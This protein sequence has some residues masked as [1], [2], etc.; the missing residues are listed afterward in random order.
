MSRPDYVIVGPDPRRTDIENPGGQLTATTGLL[1]YARQEGL[2]LA[3]IDTL[4]G[5]FPVPPGYVRIAKVI[6]R[7]LQFLWYSSV[8]RPRMGAIIFSAGPGSFVERGMTGLIARLFRVRAVI[9]IRSGRLAPLLGARSPSGIFISMLAR[10]QP[11]ILVQGRS[12]LVDLERAGVE[13][14][15]VRVVPNW[16]SP[17]RKIAE[18]P[19]FAAEGKPIRFLFVGWLVVEKGIREL[20]QA[21]LSLASAGRPFHLT[22]VGGGN[23]EVELEK[24]IEKN[25]ISNFVSLAGWVKPD[26]VEG[27]MKDADVFVLPT[28]FEGLPNALV[29]A[30]SVGLPAISTPVG[31]IPDSLIDQHNGFLVPPRDAVSLAD[32]MARYIGNPDLVLKHS[33]IAI[34]TVKKNHDFH[35]N[36]RKILSAVMF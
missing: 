35:E 7:L 5:S 29:E 6:R 1:E 16:V 27:Y 33:T 36:C 15:R 24:F 20:A 11:R 3:F 17:D 10:L 22:V 26:E 23:L 9:C 2:N 4:Q 31:A 25:G 34:D 28:Y 8:R 30:F 21:C 32:A 19:R 12:W 18:S 14:H 13:P